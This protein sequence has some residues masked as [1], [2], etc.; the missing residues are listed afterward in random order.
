MVPLPHA[1]LQARYPTMLPAGIL[2]LVIATA[3]CRRVARRLRTRP[4]VAWLLLAGFGGILAVTIAP[5]RRALTVGVSGPVTCDLSRLGPAPL[6]V[7]ARLD[8]PLLNILAFVPLGIAIGL[9]P[10]GRPRLALA[11]AGALLPLAIETTQALVVALG[12]ACESGD[13]FDNVLGLLI[14][15]GVGLLLGS[16]LVRR[17]GR[18]ASAPVS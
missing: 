8:D 9:L 15:L 4:A 17:Q 14:G 7:Y 13:V 5:S 2:S 10:A 11:I 12:R 3:L 1:L 16:V 6:W 18:G